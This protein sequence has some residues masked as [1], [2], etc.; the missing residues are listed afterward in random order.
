ME[1]AKNNFEKVPSHHVFLCWEKPSRGKRDDRLLSSSCFIGFARS[2][3]CLLSWSVRFN[4]TGL[5]PN[6]N[7][8]AI[9]YHASQQTFARASPT[10]TI[11]PPHRSKGNRNLLQNVKQSYLLYLSSDRYAEGCCPFSRARWDRPFAGGLVQPHP[12]LQLDILRVRERT[13]FGIAKNHHS[14]HGSH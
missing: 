4:P 10:I 2:F 9:H 13:P 12:M 3:C 1:I 5:C 6:I 7:M 8:S 11:T 14:G